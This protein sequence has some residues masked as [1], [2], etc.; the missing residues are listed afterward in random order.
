LAI[1]AVG[2]RVGGKDMGAA[3]GPTQQ[4][5][6]EEMNGGEPAHWPIQRDPL[7]SSTFAPFGAFVGLI[8]KGA[9]AIS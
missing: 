7:P 9:L 3:A 5:E 2:A 8:P 6:C 4:R 1:G